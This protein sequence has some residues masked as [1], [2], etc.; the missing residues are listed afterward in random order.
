MADATTPQSWED[1]LRII[2]AIPN[3]TGTQQRSYDGT[4]DN[5]QTL[6]NVAG[7]GNNVRVFKGDG[8]NPS[9]PIGW[10]DSGP[11]WMGMRSYNGPLSSI[12]YNDPTT[13]AQYVVSPK[14]AKNQDTNFNKTE[15]DGSSG[16]WDILPVVGM[17]ASA[18]LG[19]SALGSALGGTAAG[20]GS[21]LGGTTGALEGGS[22]LGGGLTASGGGTSLG[23][24]LTLGSGGTGFTA[25][26]TGMGFTAGGAGGSLGS[27][28][29]GSFAGETL[30]GLSALVPAAGAGSG[31][32]GIASSM[33]NLAP[34]SFASE[35]GLSGAANALGG[36]GLA[37]SIANGA[38][39]LAGNQAVSNLGSKAVDLLGNKAG[40]ALLGAALGGVNGSSQSGNQ[41]ITTQQA[42]DPRMASILYGSNGNNGFINNQILS[43]LTNPQKAGMAGFGNG[44]DSY[45]G[46]SGMNQLQGA[47]NAAGGLL[48]SNIG[49]PTMQAAQINAPS[50]NSTNLAPAYQ[51]MVYGQA[52][53]NPYLTGAIQKGI[54]QS[55]NAFNDQISDITKNLTQTV[56][57]SIR[58]GA[59]V[60]GAMGGSRQGIAEGRALQDFSTQMGRALSQFGQNN[61]DA[62]VGAQAG[63]YD[64]DRNRALSAM[65]GL[66]AQQYG[67]ATQNAGFQQQANQNN[68]QS[69]LDTNRLNSANQIAG[70]NASS[71]L[72]NNAYTMGQNNDAYGLNKVGKVSSLLSPYTGLGSSTTQT[73]PLYENKVGNVLGGAT[74][75]LGLWNAMNS[76]GGLFGGSGNQNSL[77]RNNSGLMSQYNMSPSDLYGL[78]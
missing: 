63:A 41:T 3:V 64:A 14:S 1:Y 11:D 54:N 59:L 18:Y 69:Q 62:A 55:T 75:G 28:G 44:V 47:F 31:A 23:S 60:N 21:A 17:M 76:G 38:K 34:G 35:A 68:M 33:G 5:Y 39:D 32:A 72:L 22:T 67:V 61:T 16:F 25:G 24:G 78:G 4:M 49:S 40:A 45:L 13:G 20:T 43:Q 70:I 71:D 8:Y 19:G 42:P 2:N 73:Q 53:A 27:L 10:S 26:G 58:S 15:A 9:K 77:I 57:P 50:Q 7:L 6:G 36:G 66:G 37:N 56:L 74:A 46:S 30:G 52:G 48:N 65:G 51:D 12:M 29:A